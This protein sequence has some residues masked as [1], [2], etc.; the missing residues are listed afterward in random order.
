MKSHAQ[1]LIAKADAE[2]EALIGGIRIFVALSLGCMLVLILLQA[3]IIPKKEWVNILIASGVIFLIFFLGLSSLIMVFYKR[4]RPWMAWMFGFGDVLLI[5]SNLFLSVNAAKASTLAL[6]ATPAAFLI[7]LIFIVQSFRYRVK[8]QMALS[9][10][11]LLAVGGL[12][13]RDPSELSDAST[14]AFLVHNYSTYPNIARI[15]LLALMAGI[16]SFAVWRSTRLLYEAARGSELLANTTRFLP[17]EL[18]K[19]MTDADLAEMQKGRR[20][21]LVIMFVDIRGFTA[22]SESISPEEVSRFL[23]AF[24]T[25]VTDA[26]V[27]RDGVIDKF[28]GDGALIVFGLN[29]DI[30]EAARSAIAA[31]TSLLK[32]IDDWNDERRTANLNPIRIVISLHSGNVIAAAIGDMRRLEFSVVGSAVNEASR[33]E[34]LAKHKDLSL[35]ASEPVVEHSD[36]NLETWID[37]GEV[38]LRGR[39]RPLRLYSFKL[40]ELSTSD[41][42]AL[43]N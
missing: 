11:L 29:T 22:M 31:A 12:L 17:A 43:Q 9:L 3:E 18:A 21:D 1:R 16:A 37:M 20:E 8:L 34:T 27:G 23:G 25:R 36:L 35:V 15:V 2:A 28:I 33:I 4:Y 42:S 41:E 30:G 32:S 40:E 5:G 13:F 7:G 38:E 24:R 14:I 26:I 39:T 19:S 10:V 6:L